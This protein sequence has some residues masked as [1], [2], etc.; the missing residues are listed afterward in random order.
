[1]NN[2]DLYIQELE[3]SKVEIKE[4]II[5]KGV[6]PEGGLSSYAAAIN[7]IEDPTL[8]TDDLGVLINENGSYYYTP[9]GDG[10]GS[11]E[12]TVDVEIPTFETETLS[13]ELTENGTYNY[14]PA[15]DGY[16]SVNVTVEVA[17]SGGGDTGSS[18][19][20]FG[21]IGYTPEDSERASA[22]IAAN[23]A[24]SKSLFDAWVPSKTSTSNLYKNNTN[25]VYAPLI[26]TSKVTNMQ[27]MFNGCS[28]LTYVPQYNT[29]KVMFMNNMFA[30]CNSLTTISQFDTS[31]VVAMDYLFQNCSAITSVPQLNFG[32]AES[33]NYMFNYDS[34]TTL[35]GFINFGKKKSIY[36]T[37][38]IL[39][40]CSKLTYESIM[41]VI[42]NLYDRATA[43]Y[44]VLTLKLHANVLALLSDDDIAIATNKGW[45][46]SS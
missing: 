42:N 40:S 45:T 29:S 17:S 38:S 7:S 11:V 12:V 6:T 39:S 36:G 35:G 37:N 18:G 8:E 24:Y 10:F 14:T 31:S 21:V 43:G 5:A 34:L 15:V 2:I 20:D 9:E 4:A 23:I 30:G 44:S 32:N 19:V 25:L 1:M 3:A 41:N 33:V 13:V 26:D 28:Q 22:P 16:S 27:N 46:I